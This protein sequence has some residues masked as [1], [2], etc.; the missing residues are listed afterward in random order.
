MYL[1]GVYPNSVNSVLQSCP[2][3]SQ[4]AAFE[5]TALFLLFP[6]LLDHPFRNLESFESSGNTTVDTLNG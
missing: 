4:P 5:P 3:I 2:F 1:S 6:H